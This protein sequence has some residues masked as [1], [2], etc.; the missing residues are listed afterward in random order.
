MPKI[1]RVTI[2]NFR[3]IVELT[4]DMTDLTVIVGDNDCGKSNVLRALNLFFNDRTNPET[5]FSFP[6]DHN[7]FSEP[8]A[9]RAPEISVEVDLELPSTYR[10]NNGDL[11]RWRKRWRSDGL[12]EEDEY[13]GIR[14]SRK[15]RGKGFTEA[16]VEIDGR[17]RV[18]ALLSRIQFEYVP[19]VR[20]ADFFRKL[21][22]RI[23]QVIASAS[24]EPVRQSSGQLEEVIS[25]AVSTLLSDIDKE[26]KD[27][28]RLS[29]PND[30]TPLFQ[31]LD[32]LA[33]EK[34][35]SLDSRGDG[36]KARYIPLIL[37]F[38]AE[39]NREAAGVSPTFIWAYEEP[40]NNLEFRRAQALADAFYK[41]AEDELSQVILTTHSPIFY[42]MHEDDAGRGLCSAYHLTHTGPDAGTEARSA[43][44]ASVSLD[45]S[46]GAMAII[47]PH[48]RAAQDALTEAT[49]QA[50]DLRSKLE[51]FNQQN[52]PAL[53]VE[54]PTDYVVFKRLL[55]LFRPQ[56][57]QA[58]FLAEPPARAG[59]NYVT[60]MLR[61]WE[62]RTK[63]LPLAERR[64]A[65]GIVDGDGEGDRAWGSF[66]GE[67]I[68]WKHVSLIRL[69]RPAHLVD[70]CDLGVNIPVCLEELWPAGVWQTAD[71]RGWLSTRPKKGLVGET[72]LQ[73]LAEQDERLS[74]L[75][76]DAW[77]PF[78]E[79]RVNVA[80][81]PA[82]VDWAAHMTALPRAQIEPLAA[83]PLRVLDEAIA[84][85]G[86]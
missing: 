24:E 52:R 42:N 78:F 19:A 39:R 81:D 76:D 20:S 40:E 12:Q 32:F 59:A 26:L 79:R 5:P 18:P 55:E 45:E 29:L 41:L 23:F 17:S 46:M 57:F 15:K 9:K 2:R 1:R 71:Q 74:D 72:L 13:W 22:G 85:L 16:V 58:L 31:S 3:S 25:T 73:R 84:K 80:P 75:I 8:K 69:S 6:D 86:I 28:S 56:Q 47:A 50:T 44:E 68:G 48:I 65:V 49:A 7:R 43:A 53:F 64:T 60:N 67:K 27:T 10:K 30:L 38:I 33:G 70:A 4:M 66:D 83:E 37:K 54:G 61:S 51:Q 62:F 63:H 21:R 35:I 77:R 34:S 11:I 14:R 36:I 82:K